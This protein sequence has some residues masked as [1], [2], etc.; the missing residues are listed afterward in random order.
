MATTTPEK[1]EPT[2][3]QKEAARTG[4]CVVGGCRCEAFESAGFADGFSQ[5]VCHHTQWGHLVRA[6]A[7][8]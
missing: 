6:E 3:R 1:K 8:A 4:P 7:P 2:P 5:C